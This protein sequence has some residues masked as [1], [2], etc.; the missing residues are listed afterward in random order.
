[1]AIVFLWGRASQ[2]S[3]EHMALRGHN[4]EYQG[5]LFQKSTQG[6]E[7]CRHRSASLEDADY[8]SG[9]YAVYSGGE[10]GSI[11][12]AWFDDETG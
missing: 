12:A 8:S 4:T 9:R 10:V 5:V 2:V 11:V 6:T 7:T 1:M 3:K